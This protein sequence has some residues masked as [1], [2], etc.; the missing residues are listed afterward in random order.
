MFQTYNEE[1]S[2]LVSTVQIILSFP[3]ELRA[4]RFPS[5]TG[6][7]CT[8]KYDE[9]KPYRKGKSYAEIE[10]LCIKK[11]Y[12]SERERESKKR[13]AAFTIFTRVQCTAL[14]MLK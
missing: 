1:T 10:I 6:Q 9:F 7:H 12:E 5:M 3:Q 4:V 13:T 8:Q 11:K 2:Q 14:F